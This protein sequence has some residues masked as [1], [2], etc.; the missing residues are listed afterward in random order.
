MEQ[1]TLKAQSD[2]LFGNYEPEAKALVT[3][4]FLGSLFFQFKTYGYARL[5]T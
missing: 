1:K 3:K 2:I 4:T 5:L